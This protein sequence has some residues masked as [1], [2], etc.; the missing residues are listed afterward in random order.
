MIEF[1]DILSLLMLQAGKFMAIMYDQVK[2]K[3]R[4]EISS[5]QYKE[6]LRDA[7]GNDTRENDLV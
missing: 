5:E 6:R 4:F 1:R 2:V 7:S 3:P